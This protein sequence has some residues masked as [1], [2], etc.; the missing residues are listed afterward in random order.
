MIKTR[1]NIAK[2]IEKPKTL[3]GRIVP[4][5]VAKAAIKENINEASPAIATTGK[6]TAIMLAVKPKFLPG[7]D[8]P[9]P[10]LGIVSI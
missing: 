4:D 5:L 6:I 2:P 7:T 3:P 1:M 10:Q 8:I 9:Y